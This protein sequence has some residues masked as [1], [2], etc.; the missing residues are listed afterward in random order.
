M[1]SV[2]IGDYRYT[3]FTDTTAS[4]EVLDVTKTSYNDMLSVVAIEGRLY[5][6]TNLE[7]CFAGSNLIISP[8]ISDNA[9]FIHA[10]F[11][12]CTSLTQPP[13]I[14]NSVTDMGAC[15]YG[16][17]LLTT[18]PEIPNSVT[19]MD[20]CFRGCTSLTTA[21]KIPS[22]VTNMHSCFES[23][24]SLTTPPEIPNGVTNIGSCFGNCALL[25]TAPAIPNSVTN[26][27][28]CFYGCA[29]LTIAPVIPSSVTNVA[30]CFSG[31]TSLTGDI[32]IMV[33]TTPTYIDCFYNTT[34]SI[35]LRGAKT[36]TLQ[37]LASTANRNN[38]YVNTAPT[39]LPIIIEG[40]PMSYMTDSGL[41]Q[42]SLQTDASLISCE[43]PHNNGTV[44]T[45][46][47][48]ALLDLYSRTS[49]I[50]PTLTSETTI[51]GITF[52]PTRDGG[53]YLNGQAEGDVNIT[54][55]SLR[56][57]SG[58][59]YHLSGASAVIVKQGAQPLNNMSCTYI[60]G[61]STRSYGRDS[62][63]SEED[64]VVLYTRSNYTLSRIVIETRIP[65]GKNFSNVLIYPKLR[66]VGDA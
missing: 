56:Y 64:F 19:N 62:A 6:V 2:I 43:V 20:D 46:L 49:H 4:V 25:T 52:T 24:T 22:G 44:I 9:V 23:C 55:F 1:A 26:M 65:S 14:P 17:T 57:P 53:I 51:G 30:Y 63:P 15:F 18:P 33:G 36:S 5:D 40:S 10:C 11:S 41:V 66:L 29:S 47:Q 8:K 50:K 3:T 16:C 54:L 12:G 7:D 45:T 38:V 42:L 59:R 60:R 61:S 21:P 37:S 13:I 28:F 58:G 48:D 39:S 32:Y 27:S 31:C 34:Q 35:T